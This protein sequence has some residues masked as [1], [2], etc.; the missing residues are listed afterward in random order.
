MAR[1]ST[2]E[3]EVRLSKAYPSASYIRGVLYWGDGSQ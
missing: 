2:C 1:V 3:R